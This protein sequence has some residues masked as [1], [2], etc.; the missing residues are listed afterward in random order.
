[1]LIYSP[2]KYY[3][4]ETEAD[5]NNAL[6]PIV[7]R[8]LRARGICTE[9]ERMRFLHPDKSILRDPFLLHD[10]DKAA[11]RIERAVDRFCR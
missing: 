6:S 8:A 11:E 3:T 1:M 10:M 7:M 5:R 4:P 2:S 9:E